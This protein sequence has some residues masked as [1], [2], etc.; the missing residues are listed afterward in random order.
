VKLLLG[1]PSL[2]N[3]VHL[4]FK[5]VRLLSE[6]KRIPKIGQNCVYNR[7]I[8]TRIKI[9]QLNGIIG[10]NMN[11]K[12]ALTLDNSLLTTYQVDGLIILL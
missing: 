6:L 2:L 8:L 7:M 1:F 10:M 11:P 9:D 4:C 12:G 5:R 3:I